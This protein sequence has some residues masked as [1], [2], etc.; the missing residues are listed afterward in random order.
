LHKKNKKASFHFL[1]FGPSLV[2]I[3][4]N[5]KH[6]GPFTQAKSVFTTVSARIKTQINLNHLYSDVHLKVYS[7]ECET[8]DQE[9][10]SEKQIVKFETFVIKRIV[11]QIKGNPPKKTTQKPIEI[12][13]ENTEVR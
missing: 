12:I 11:I 7:L 2:K 8:G 9:R 1:E 13:H 6:F 4:V 5:Q 10:K 3:G